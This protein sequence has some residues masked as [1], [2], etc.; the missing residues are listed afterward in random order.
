M[1]VTQEELSKRRFDYAWDW[2]KAHAKQRTDMFN[3]FL[4]ITGVLANAYV[5]LR[6]DGHPYLA[7]ELGVLG[8]VTAV[9]F[10][11][12][13]CRN[14][15]LVDKSSK[16]L[17]FIERNELFLGMVDSDKSQLGLVHEDCNYTC[18]PL[19]KS[20]FGWL[21]CTISHTWIFRGVELF[22]AVMWIAFTINTR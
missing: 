4:I 18:L 10:L 20:K 15:A 12:L 9:G 13:D 21:D 17:A 1:S 8:I 14:K 3:Y 7:R 16:I 19:K 11:L 2:F 5:S 6:K 22:I